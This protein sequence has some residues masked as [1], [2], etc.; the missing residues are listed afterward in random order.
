MSSNN[1]KPFMLL[2]KYAWGSFKFLSLTN[3]CWEMHSQE[4]SVFTFLHYS[5]LE[6]WLYPLVI[7]KKEFTYGK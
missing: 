1:M 5:R 2:P 3:M 6:L 4:S 7:S